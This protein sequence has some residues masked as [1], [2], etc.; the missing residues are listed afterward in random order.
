M[1]FV[2][3]GLGM[4]TF[5]QSLC[6]TCLTVFVLMASVMKLMK[7]VLCFVVDHG[8]FLGESLILWCLC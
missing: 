8:R 3:H 4:E 5:T 7:V 1:G 2:D 6:V